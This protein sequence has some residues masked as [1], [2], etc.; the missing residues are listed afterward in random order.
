MSIWLI[1]F[2][3]YMSWLRE[4]LYFVRLIIALCSILVHRSTHALGADNSQTTR[5]STPSF[6]RP[7]HTAFGE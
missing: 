6:T 2:N 7:P 5:A 4:H 1:T 3:V